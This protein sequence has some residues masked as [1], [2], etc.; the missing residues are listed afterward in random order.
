MLGFTTYLLAGL[1]GLLTVCCVVN[2]M[3]YTRAELLDINRNNTALPSLSQPVRKFL[4]ENKLNNIPQTT[5]GCQSGRKKQRNIKA[6]LSLLQSC[7]ELIETAGINT[8]NLISI[9][10][11]PQIQKS[12]PLLFAIL[13][14]RSLKNKHTAITDYIIDNKLDIVAFTETWL[15]NDGSDDVTVSHM[16]IPGYTFSH[17][18]RSYSVGGGVALLHRSN[19]KFSMIQTSTYASFEILQM[20]LK[21]DSKP[22]LFNVLYRPPPSPTNGFTSSQFL[23]EFEDLLDSIFLDSRMFIL[24]GDMNVHVDDPSNSEA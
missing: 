21:Y 4:V 7:S 6:H 22:I 13:N 3:G 17:V 23:T 16:S 2:T 20:E 15:S 5:R 24:A 10:L 18:P 1:L 14:A 11:E 8:N 19:L 9:P 12:P